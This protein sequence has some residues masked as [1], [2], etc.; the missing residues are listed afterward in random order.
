M[1]SVVRRFFLKSSLLV[2]VI[3]SAISAFVQRIQFWV[4]ANRLGP[5]MPLTHWMLHFKSTMRWL[6]ERRLGRFGANAEIRPGS[7]A[8]HCQNI[9]IGE[10]VVIRPGT[11]LFATGDADGTIRIGNGVLIGSGVHIY[12]SNHEFRD[13]KRLIIDQGHSPSAG[14]TLEEGCWIGAG[15]MI[16][17]GVTIGKNAVVGAGSIVT[18]SVLPFTVNAGNPAKMIKRLTDD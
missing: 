14:V 4:T 12:V 10:R 16:L 18:K 7:Y 9:F 13:T 1:F 3:V 8:V 11:H 5:D 17:P 15:A 2:A 6:C